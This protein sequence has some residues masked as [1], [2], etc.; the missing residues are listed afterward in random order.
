LVGD[1]ELSAEHIVVATGAV[2]R[3]LGI[4]GEDMLT[5]SDQFLSLPEMPGEVIFV[6]GGYI[7]MEFAHVACQAGAKVTVIQRGPHI[8]KSFEPE[9][10]DELKQASIDAGIRIHTHTCVDRVE[11]K[12]ARRVVVCEQ[13]GDTATH[14]ADMIVHGAGRV[15]ELDGLDLDKGGVDFTSRGVSV[16][17]FLQ[18]PSNPA[19]YAI[20]DAAATPY[21]LAPTADME[22]ETA[23]HN[24]VHGN[25][26]LC[27][28]RVVPSVVFTQPPLARVGL[29]E[30]AAQ[31][32]TG[33]CDVHSGIMTQW[34]SS[35]R[36]GQAHARYKVIVDQATRQILGAHLVCHRAEEMI[37]VFA[38]AMRFGLTTRDLKTMLW[39]YPTHISDI[40][41][42]I[43]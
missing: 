28:Y 35:K 26:R 10:A 19:V 5:T 18:S 14:E 30:A 39:A 36:I 12:G 33:S 13:S 34:P 31:N 17:E 7:S 29:G 1:Q 37:N 43:G 42:M 15:P 8:L 6:G 21:Q 16:N 38:M 24:I 32:R 22:G 40:K 20:G 41:Y 23:G 25:E 27:D 3:R 4:A 2:P 9:L 11:Q